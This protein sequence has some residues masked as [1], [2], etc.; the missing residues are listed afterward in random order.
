MPSV[1]GAALFGTAASRQPPR[2]MEELFG[3][4]YK[5]RR[6]NQEGG[7]TLQ[8]EAFGKLIVHL[9]G[10]QIE[11]QWQPSSFCDGERW[12]A[13]VLLGGR[14]M[15]T[16]LVVM[17]ARSMSSVIYDLWEPSPP[18]GAPPLVG[19]REQS[20]C[21]TPTGIATQLELIVDRS[22]SMQSLQAATVQG[23]NSFLTEQRS[24]P[25]A[26][27]MTMRLVVFDQEIETPW[28]EGTFLHNPDLAVTPDMVKPRGMTALLDA[29]G[30]SLT[31]TPLAPP[32]V[33]CI[34][35]DGHENSSKRFTRAQVNRLITARSNVGWTFIFLAANQDA[36]AEGATLGINAATCST[37][38]ANPEGVAGGFGSAA[39]A[40]CRGSMFGSGA[41][42]FSSAEREACFGGR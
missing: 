18:N 5:V 7:F 31:E 26:S 10:Q 35:T 6:A 40:S 42:A 41:A 4:T 23:L 32:R 28:P 30:I 37:F 21:G 13:A 22:G 11:E 27:R 2:L 39:A 29:I 17:G 19:R 34:V 16:A 14:T 9:Q 15:A 20:N 25:H 33:V 12:H 36:I 24:M 3:Q 8:F 1:A 38:S